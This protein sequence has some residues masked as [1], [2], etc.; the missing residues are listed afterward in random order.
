[1]RLS[2]IKGERVLD[3]I[4]DLVE[5][6]AGI[7]EDPEALALFKREPVPEGTDPR[8]FMLGRIKRSVPR[9][10]KSH[11]ADLVAIL[12][13]LEGVDAAEYAESMTIQKVLSDVMDLVTDGEFSAFLSSHEP[14]RGG[15][16]S[17][18]RSESTE[19]R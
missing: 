8:A 15:T 10:M 7:A 16:P 13:A 11:R 19:A 4:A 12:A 9:L 6:V 17:G 5:P 3:V 1:M 2:E 14:S 18:S